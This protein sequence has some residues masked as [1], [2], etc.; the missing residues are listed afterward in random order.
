MSIIIRLQYLPWDASTMDIRHFFQ[1]LSIP[2]GGVHIIGGENGDAF[3]AFSTDEDAR[4]AM[5]ND[6]GY[7][8]STQIKL[9]LSSKSEMQSVIAMAREAA[10]MSQESV[11]RSQSFKQYNE[12]PS[13]QRESELNLKIQ[14]PERNFNSRQNDYGNLNRNYTEEFDVK[15]PFYEQNVRSS[16]VPR[17]SGNFAMS[18]PGNTRSLNSGSYLNSRKDSPIKPIMNSMETQRT[19]F[20]NYENQINRNEKS[21]AG[22]RSYN[23]V[24]P[25]REEQ[26]FSENSRGNSFVRNE[27]FRND[28]VMKNESVFRNE[29]N[30][31]FRNDGGMRNEPFVR[32]EP[33]FNQ[34]SYREMESRHNIMPE[35]GRMD[36]NFQGNMS[37]RLEPARNNF[38]N[39]QHNQNYHDSVSNDFSVNNRLFPVDPNFNRMNNDIGKYVTIDNIPMSFSTQDIRSLFKDYD[40]PSSTLKIEYDRSGKKTGRVYLRLSS[41]VYVDHAFRLNGKL[42]HGRRIRVENCSE[43]EYHVVNEAP[44]RT[45]SRS[46]SSSPSKRTKLDGNYLVIK[47]IPL[48]IVYK[49]LGDAKVAKGGGP[50]A[51]ILTNGRESGHVLIEMEN[52]DSLKHVVNQFKKV[53]DGNVITVFRIPRAEYLLRIKKSKLVT[54]ENTLPK[55]DKSL[56]CVKITGLNWV[57]EE[58]DL[59]KFFNDSKIPSDAVHLMLGRDG[60]NSGLGYVEFASPED[61]QRALQK[62]KRYL[63][64]RYLYIKGL[65]LKEMI[66]QIEATLKQGKGYKNDSIKWIKG[67][68]FRAPPPEGTIVYMKNLSFRTQLEDILEFF[69]GFQVLPDSVHLQYKD[70]IPTGDGM[71]TFDSKVEAKRAISK[72]DRREMLGRR[73]HLMF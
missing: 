24:P 20:R 62:D 31:N 36:N 35:F 55:V 10:Q 57:S 71:I 1:N 42:V 46:R 48:S 3:I 8:G 59:R 68:T 45:R 49:L 53:I 14:T 54:R 25:F 65:R 26:N 13:Q 21:Y 33:N 56:T 11:G 32:N 72:L 6:G 61:C 67:L 19:D 15:K 4:Q 28:S 41:S 60:N 52:E 5:K 58:K 44:K 29:N 9:F 23:E 39:F 51:E 27:P 50:Y 22:F 47:S 2:D 38:G 7:I 30:Q 37:L 66:E 43:R 63:D 16:E 70:D 73:V 17:N 40:L 18:E 34:Q 64:G 12:R 69:E